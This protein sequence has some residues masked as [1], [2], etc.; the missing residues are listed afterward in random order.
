MQSM[1]ETAAKKKKKKVATL[2][3]TYQTNKKHRIFDSG[4]LEQQQL[5]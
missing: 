1:E 2:N 5:N 4:W 3:S